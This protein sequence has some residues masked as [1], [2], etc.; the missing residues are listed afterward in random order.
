LATISALIITWLTGKAAQLT[1]PSEDKPTTL[2]ILFEPVDVEIVN[3]AGGGLMLTVV[4][5][6]NRKLNNSFRQLPLED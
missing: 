5:V 6:R 3:N 1:K 4:I 2:V